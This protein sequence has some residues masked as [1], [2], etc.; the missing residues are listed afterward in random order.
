MPR[1]TFGA[2]GF[3]KHRGF[4]LEHQL[5]N[6]ALN[7]GYGTWRSSIVFPSTWLVHTTNVTLHWQVLQ[8]WSEIHLYV[9]LALA[10]LQQLKA[11]LN[12]GD[13]L[14]LQEVLECIVFDCLY[15]V[16]SIH[17]SQTM[18][19]WPGPIGKILRR[20][21]MDS[22]TALIH[23]MLKAQLRLLPLEQ[24]SKC[25]HAQSELCFI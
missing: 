14:V 17:L 12:M 24:P 23:S 1:S 10:L 22:S 21:R 3:V 18:H 13:W 7:S 16:N 11:K 5:G 19:Y 4:S 9:R 15:N 8:A 20:H 25:M 6:E 2:G